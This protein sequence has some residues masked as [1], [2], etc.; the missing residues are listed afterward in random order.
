[1]AQGFLTPHDG[2]LLDGRIV[3]RRQPQNTGVRFP[4]KF[5][6]LGQGNAVVARV[7]F[8]ENQPKL[9]FE[10]M[11][12]LVKK[13]PTGLPPGEYTLR[14]DGGTEAATFTVEELDQSN[15]VL[16]AANKL[17]DLL[18]SRSDSLFI[19]VAVAALLDQ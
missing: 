12:E 2:R 19:Q 14:M 6:L 11:P 10:Q 16:V 15:E 13:L 7:D 4:A 18:A 5:A 3:I 9:T 8:A 1:V 17:A